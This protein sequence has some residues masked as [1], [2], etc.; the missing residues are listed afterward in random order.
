LPLPV[1]RPL[2]NPAIAKTVFNRSQPASCLRRSATTAPGA[3]SASEG[4]VPQIVTASNGGMNPERRCRSWT[5][6]MC[7]TEADCPGANE[8]ADPEIRVDLSSCAQ[9][10]QSQ[11]SGWA[12]HTVRLVAESISDPVKTARLHSSDP[13]PIVKSP[14]CFS[15]SGQR[16]SPGR[17]RADGRFPHVS[18][19][20]GG[21]EKAFLT[22]VSSPVER[23][24]GEKRWR[25]RVVTVLSRFD[26]DVRG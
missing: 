17:G 3:I 12:I 1:P 15:S 7:Q 14:W 5:P 9:F 16:N 18:F 23:K 21:E 6:A 2:R 4:W 25:N 20:A 10:V 24:T 26:R 22:F 13:G 19:T 11:R 8:K